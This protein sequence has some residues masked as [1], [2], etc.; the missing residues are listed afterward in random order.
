MVVHA[1][2][3]LEAPAV[4]AVALGTSASRVMVV[5][6]WW[7]QYVQHTA[8]AAAGPGV[9]SGSSRARCGQWQQQGQVWSTYWCQ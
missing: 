5:V 3:A 9:V 8:V 4:V 1:G 6:G 7:W 2:P